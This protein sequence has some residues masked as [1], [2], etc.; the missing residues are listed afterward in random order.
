[1]QV[2]LAEDASLRAWFA[3]AVTFTPESG[4]SIVSRIEL[5]ELTYLCRSRN[6]LLSGSRL[7]KATS[8]S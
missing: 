8:A 6:P 7:G 2:A 5:R 4:P 3:L 1:M